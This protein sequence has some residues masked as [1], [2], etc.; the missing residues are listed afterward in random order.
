MDELDRFIQQN[1]NTK[2]PDCGMEFPNKEQYAKHLQKFCS[3]SIYNDVDKMDRRMLE[4]G[5]YKVQ[6]QQ[7][8]HYKDL[9][10]D[11]LKDYIQTL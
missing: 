7:N 6:N 11:D 4:L 9:K 1:T 8:P 10:L 5:A 2:C 3:G